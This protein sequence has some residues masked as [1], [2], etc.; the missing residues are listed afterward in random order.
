MHAVTGLSE[1]DANNGWFQFVGNV[2]WFV[3]TYNTGAS[4]RVEVHSR[5]PSSGYQSGGDW[6]TWFSTGDQS[7]GWFQ[8]VGND[9]YFVKTRNTG[10]SNRIEVH[11]ATA[12]SGYQ[13]SSIHL[14]TWF[15]TGDQSNGWFQVG[16]K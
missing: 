5:T 9:L 1:A 12:G 15:G 13:G 2:L 4:G 7:N 8:L 14:S 3:K 16:A 6:A 11:S 10:S